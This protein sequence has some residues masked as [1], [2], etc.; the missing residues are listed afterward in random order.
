[1]EG[2][3]TTWPGMPNTTHVEAHKSQE[4]VNSQNKLII[5][6]E[7]FLNIS[8]HMLETSYNLNLGHLFKIALELKIYMWQKLKPKKT[9]NVS[10]ATTY[11]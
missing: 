4:V 7:I 1:M 6:E 9:K 10:R 8:K 3:N 5:V 11:K 2:W